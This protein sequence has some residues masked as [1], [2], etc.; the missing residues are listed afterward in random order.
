MII[1]A[2]PCLLLFT[3]GCQNALAWTAAGSV[4]LPAATIASR[5]SRSSRSVPLTRLSS[6]SSS[7]STDELAATSVSPPRK[8]CVVTVDCRLL[9]E[10]D[11]VPE[12]LI[13]GVVLNADDPPARLSFVLGQGNFLPGLH[14]LLLAESGEA[15]L[16]SIGDKVDQI[17]LDAGWGARRDDL[18]ATTS[19]EDSGVDPSQISVGSQLYLSNGVPCFVTEVT[20]ATFTIDANP[21]LAGASYAATVELVASEEGPRVV[22]YE[23]TLSFNSRFQVA[24]FALGCF[25]GGELA[26]M[27]EP[28]VVG[29]GVGYTQGQIEQPTYEQVCSGTTGHTEAIVVTYDP[30]LV[31][32]E[33]LGQLAMERLGENRYLR[34]Q[35]GNDK[36]TQYR[37]GIYYHTQ[38]QKKI[39]EGIISSYGED[40]QT[41]CLPAQKFH[42]A[43]DYHQ[44]YLL[45]GGQS[46]RKRDSSVIRCYG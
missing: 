42:F 24:T 8:G 39:A 40:C 26:Y 32:Y 1:R 43:E 37:H 10:G 25:W 35:V 9:P 30:A 21:P 33:R 23:E 36:G 4:R 28:G 14:D 29:T 38:E 19:F 45:K 46:A 2:F 41:E 3:F 15:K 31:T 18:V 16:S 20:E 22:P 17:S 5:T 44:Q 7:P 11:F 12:P 34:N 27:R 6:T 13:D